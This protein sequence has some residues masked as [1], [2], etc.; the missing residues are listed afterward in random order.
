M[1][2]GAKILAEQMKKEVNVSDIDHVHIRDDI[3]VRQTPKKSVFM[4]MRFHMMWDPVR[5]PPGVQ[6]FI[7]KAMSQR[8]AVL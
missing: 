1:R 4:L 8:T 3:K 6:D 7:M 5:K 2:A